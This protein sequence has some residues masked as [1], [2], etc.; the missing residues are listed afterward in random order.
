MSIHGLMCVPVK[1]RDV[2]WLAFSL[3]EAIQLE[4]S[5]IPPY[6]CAYWSI[7]QGD[8]IPATT[9]EIASTI[10]SIVIQEML[11]MGLACNMLAGIG[12]TPNIYSKNFSPR[13][14][15]A[16]P[17]HIQEELVVGLAGLSRG[18]PGDNEQV[19]KFMQIELPEH[20]LAKRAD[21]EFATIGEFYDALCE[22]LHLVNPSFSCERQLMSNRLGE[23]TKI[24][25]LPQAQASIDLIKRQGEGT[26]SSPFADG[27]KRAIA[28][29]HQ[30]AHYYRFG[31]VHAERRLRMDPTSPSGWSFSGAPYPFPAAADLYLMAEVPPEGYP[32]SD[33]FDRKYTAMLK[34]LHEAWAKP[35]PQSLE[36]AIDDMLFALSQAAIDLLNAGYPAD[37]GRGI[38]GPDF[39]FLSV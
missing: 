26:S 12:G 30:L 27:R 9:I 38:K 2:Q 35:D 6:L 8:G 1:E 31:E 4:W 28:P 3:Q 33:N 18:I 36:D 24:A 7:K 25:S 22:T 10:R 21:E 5:T 20:P 16:L 15:S 34:R 11:H 14:P 29:A 39:R 37:C 17:G 13:Y 32:E 23:L 19:A